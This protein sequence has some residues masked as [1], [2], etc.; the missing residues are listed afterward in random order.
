MLV[1]G[2]YVFAGVS[3][4]VCLFVCLFVTIC[5]RNV[6]LGRGLRSSSASSLLMHLCGSSG[7]FNQVIFHMFVFMIITR[8]ICIVLD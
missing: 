7:N 6:L 2:S 4:S 3:L 5:G 1:S 8:I